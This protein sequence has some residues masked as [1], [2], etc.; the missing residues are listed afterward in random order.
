MAYIDQTNLPSIVGTKDVIPLNFAVGSEAYEQ[1]AAT[2]QYVISFS[3]IPADGDVLSIQSPLLGVLTITF[4]SNPTSEVD[5]TFNRSGHFSLSAFVNAFW[6]WISYLG[7]VRKLY[8]VAWISNTQIRFTGVATGEDYNLSEGIEPITGFGSLLE[9]QEGRSEILKDNYEF[10]VLFSGLNSGSRQLFAIPDENGVVRFDAS[11]VLAEEDVTEKI[12]DTNGQSPE[13]VKLSDHIIIRSITYYPY[14][15]YGSPPVGRP[16]EIKRLNICNGGSKRMQ[17]NAQDIP[18]YLFRDVHRIGIMQYTSTKRMTPNGFDWLYFTFTEEVTWDL[19]LHITYADNS[20]LHTNII[21][22][23]QSFVNDEEER[24]YLPAHHIMQLQPSKDV[25]FVDIFA[26]INGSRESN[27][28]RWEWD[29]DNRPEERYWGYLNS[30]GCWEVC[31]TDGEVDHGVEIDKDFVEKSFVP[32][33]NIV[34]TKVTGRSTHQRILKVASGW[35][36]KEEIE[37]IVELLTSEHVYLRENNRW[38]PVR[39]RPGS[40]TLHGTRKYSTG[41]QFEVEFG[42]QQ[43]IWTP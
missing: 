42:E 11:E 7:D 40:W 31:R 5:M 21:A 13:L 8:S 12:P 26:S 36:S 3:S 28:I 43:E 23:Y 18:D 39:I 41:I 25:V 35:R 19:T 14:E 38:L 15:R 9:I 24:L 20:I 6:Q 10:V 1:Q 34:R 17:S 2:A 29:Y 30:L 33:F 27:V 4:N 37:K 16:T 22:N 32:E